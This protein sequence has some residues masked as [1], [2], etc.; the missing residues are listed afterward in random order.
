MSWGHGLQSVPYADATRNA[1]L[2]SEWW[3]ADISEARDSE[4]AVIW[5]YRVLEARTERS[6]REHRHDYATSLTKPPRTASPQRASAR[7]SD[8]N[9]RVVSREESA[10]PIGAALSLGSVVC[11]AF[12]ATCSTPGTGQV[13][14][15]LV[16][17]GRFAPCEGQYS[18]VTS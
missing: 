11:Q 1:E 4:Y 13:F 17:V 10:P 15:V 18:L 12:G 16:S 14:A 8:R 5:N 9:G 3:F 6:L 2:G 7:H